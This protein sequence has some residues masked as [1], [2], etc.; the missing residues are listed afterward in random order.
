MVI[1]VGARQRGPRHHSRRADRGAPVSEQDAAGFWDAWYAER[2]QI[3]SGEPNHA[4]VAV[5]AGLHPGRALDLGCG[6][7]ADSVWLAEQGWLVTGLDIA[8]TAVARAITLAASREIPDGRITWIVED[9]RAWQ[10]SDAYE[11]VSACFLPSRVDFPRC[12]D[13][14]ARRVG[15]GTRRPPTPRRPRRVSAVGRVARS[16]RSPV[17]HDRRGDRRLGARRRQVGHRPRRGAA[18]PGHRTPR[19]TAATLD[20]TVVLIRRL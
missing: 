17:P 8:A 16:R 18:P 3:W 14:P 20:D 12:H 6:E 2:D 13:P 5:V 19:R 4:L 9:L 11:L 15:C 10:P 1:R 7:G